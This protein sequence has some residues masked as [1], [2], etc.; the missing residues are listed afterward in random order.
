MRKKTKKPKVHNYLF[1][2]E[3]PTYALRQQNSRLTKEEERRKNTLIKSRIRSVVCFLRLNVLW[4]RICDL[5]KSKKNK[6]SNRAKKAYTQ[7]VSYSKWTVPTAIATSVFML[8]STLLLT[9]GVFEPNSVNVAINDSGRIMNAT[10]SAQTVGEF[11][12]N[13]E[14]I[15]GE[16]DLVETSMDMPLSEDM[17]IVIR[18]AMPVTIYSDAQ[19]YEIDMIAGT[20]SDALEKSGVSVEPTDEIY[21]SAGTYVSADMEISVVRVTTETI[22]ETEAIYYKEITKN[23]DDLAKGRTIISQEG[24]D[25]VQENTILITYKNGEEFSRETIETTVVKEAVDEITKVGT[26][27]PP[28]EPEEPEESESSSS[29]GSSSGSSSSGSSSSGSSNDNSHI[30]GTGEG[31]DWGDVETLTTAPT[32]AQIHG[33]E[34]L[35]EHASAP[36]PDASIIAQTVIIDDVTAYAATGNTTATG[37][38]PRLGTVAADPVRFPYGTKVYVPGYGYGRIEDTGSMR[39]REET[40]WDLFMLSTEECY[41]WGRKHNVKC[42]ILK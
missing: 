40:L 14:I 18:R 11:F 27:E 12:E 21:P 29:S 25:G 22:T 32:T 34:S 33:A 7:E 3:R 20:V 39:H 38:W 9:A 23:D 5:F 2:V 41:E 26:Y 8:A 31:V 37:T 1:R 15:I 24:E 10:T 4:Q 28:P 13:N 6:D 17:T 19:T 30:V 35:Y 42:Y 36:P 16:S